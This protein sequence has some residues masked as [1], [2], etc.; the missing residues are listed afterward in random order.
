M[1][2]ILHIILLLVLTCTV[3]SAQMKD[4][5][6]VL[7]IG[8]SFTYVGEAHNKLVE[9]AASQGHF[10]RM[11]AQYVGGYTFAR[12]LQRI[13]TISAI[14]RS[15]SKD[16]YDYVFLQN[17]SQ[18][19]ARYGSDPKRYPYVL[20]DAKELSGRIRQYSP[21]AVIFL[22]S[23]WSYP[24]DDFGGFGSLEVFDHLSDKGTEALA[25]AC[26]A[27]VSYIGRAFTLARSECP[28]IPL[29][30]GD[31]RHQIALGSYL[32]ACV[33]YLLIYGVHFDE[34]ASPCGLDPDMTARL[35]SVAQQAVLGLLY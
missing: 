29:L 17:Q 3:A 7:C 13:E 28:D 4:T 22:E 24:D 1:R 33:N 15:S 6:R 20:A 10:I 30:A 25:K 21:G 8:N 9:L 5:L 26:K 2:K 19:H 16:A 12:H 23:T 18:L 11:N 31:G 14:E 27:K 34:G 32:K 35:R